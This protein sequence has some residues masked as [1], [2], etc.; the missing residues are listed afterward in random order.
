MASIIDLSKLIVYQ[1]NGKI[2]IRKAKDV[3]E[4]VCVFMEE[5]A[6]NASFLLLEK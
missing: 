4:Q 2:I 3:I 6:F 5:F 1:K